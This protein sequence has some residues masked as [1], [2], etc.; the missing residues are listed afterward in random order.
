MK[1]KYQR[2]PEN[3]LKITTIRTFQAIEDIRPIWEQMQR[4]EPFP[5]LNA[6]INRF[7]SVIEASDGSVQPYIILVKENGR[8]A[9]M[10]LAR[11]GKSPVELKVGYKTLLSPKL[12]CLTIVYGGILG[13]PE[14]ELCIFLIGKLMEILHRGKVDIVYFNHLR[15]DSCVYQLSRRTPGILS[16]G[17]FPKVENHRS[18]S[19]PE[20]LDRFYQGCSKKHRGNLKRYI[21]KL[22]KE[23]PN[24]AKVITYTKEDDLDDAMKTAS[25]ISHSTYQHGLGC[26][27][28][29]NPRTRLLLATAAR[30]NW[31]RMSVLSVNGESAAFQLGLHYGKTYV[32]EQIGFD[33]KWGRLEVGTVLFLRVL[34]HICAYPDVE[35]ID[36]SF[37]DAVYKRS[38]ADRQWQEASVYIFAARPYPIFINM[39]RTSVMVLNTGLEYILNKTDLAG[40][41]KRRWR[42]LLQVRSAGKTRR[43]G[44]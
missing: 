43:V 41:I 35:I 7:L 30:R 25:E 20:N 1:A 15:T 44:R 10:V 32:L 31:L 23:Y 38:Y 26:G 11:I 42:D 9:A 19:V 12:R 36:F 17:R 40:W 22:E 28:A 6:D 18:M 29:D 4:N 14:E 21:R 34:E 24:Q 27:F 37:G 13:Q 33:P 39:V 16:R 8:P 3:D 5:T 2:N